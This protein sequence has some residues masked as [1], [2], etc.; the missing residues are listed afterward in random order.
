M[1]SHPLLLHLGPFNI[2]WDGLGFDVHCIQVH[3]YTRWSP[4]TCTSVNATTSH[5]FHTSAVSI[6]MK[7]TF[8]W[9]SS[10][11]LVNDCVDTEGF[12]ITALYVYVLWNLLGCQKLCL[13]L[14][15]LGVLVQCVLCV[16]NELTQWNGSQITKN[17]SSSFISVLQLVKVL[18]E[19][20]V[21]N[22]QIFFNAQDTYRLNKMCFYNPN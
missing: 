10:I 20:H 12:Q 19:V 18:F 16:K 4:C 15:W 3:V 2:L 14:G 6:K 8:F 9:L 17:T 1:P 7:T 5:L 11:Y 22:K 13:I 21:W